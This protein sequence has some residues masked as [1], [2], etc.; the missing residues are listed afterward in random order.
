LYFICVCSTWGMARQGRVE[1][2]NL[3][4]SGEG[5]MWGTIAPQRHPVQLLP[6]AMQ[7]HPAPIAPPLPLVSTP[8]QH[9][10]PMA[11]LLPLASAP[12]KHSGVMPPSV[13]LLATASRVQLNLM[14]PPFRPRPRPPRL[15]LPVEMPPLRPVLI[16]QDES[17]DLKW[18]VLLWLQQGGP[19]R[20]Y[21]EGM[22]V[23]RFCQRGHMQWSIRDLLLH[24]HKIAILPV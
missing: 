16:E 11:P 9:P 23:C 22:W 8:Q 10:A 17:H 6:L 13:Q 2:W 3:E 7:Q 20:V 4:D 15:L 1:A 12:Q 14:A 18:S 24:T 19:T 21:H 5:E